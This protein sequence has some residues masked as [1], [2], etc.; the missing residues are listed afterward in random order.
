MLMCLN[1]YMQKTFQEGVLGNIVH[2]PIFMRM[3]HTKSQD[4]ADQQECFSNMPNKK[5][6]RPLSGLAMVSMLNMTITDMEVFGWGFHRIRQVQRQKVVP[7]CVRQP[8]F[9][10]AFSTSLHTD[11]LTPYLK[12]RKG[13]EEWRRKDRRKKKERIGGRKKGTPIFQP[14]FRCGIMGRRGQCHVSNIN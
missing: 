6:T 5:K 1:P 10:L 4:L 14:S 12:R 3:R 11:P 7:S 9:L 2:N 13:R 8:D